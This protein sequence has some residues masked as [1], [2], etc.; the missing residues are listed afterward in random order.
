L[1]VSGDAGLKSL[2]FQHSGA[3]HSTIPAVHRQM[4]LT[5]FRRKSIGLVIWVA[6]LTERVQVTTHALRGEPKAVELSDSANFMARV[7]IHE[8]MCADERKTILMLIDVVNRYLPAICVV[9]QFAFRAILPAMQV[10]MAVLTFFWH[11]AEVKVSMTIN[12]LYY[13]VAT[14][15]REPGLRVLE[16]H[17]LPQRLPS[18]L[19]VTLL[20]WDIELVSVRTVTHIANCLLRDRNSRAK[21]QKHW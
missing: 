4:A 10:R 20:A 9:A 6:C 21:R 12:A 15:Q 16:L 3:Q 7:T 8:S 11:V 19:R 5:A 17:F 2:S 18:L 1:E 14:A 13:R